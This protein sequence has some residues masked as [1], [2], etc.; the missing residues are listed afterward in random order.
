LAH[1]VKNSDREETQLMILK[2][3]IVDC[4]FDGMRVSAIS[5]VR[6]LVIDKLGG[7]VRCTF[8]CLDFTLLTD[9]VGWKEGSRCGQFFFARVS[10]AFGRAGDVVQ[11]RS[12]GLA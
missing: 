5:I 4:P 6:E 12:T 2:D 3:L 10:F 9:N 7:G 11:A 1:L 8:A